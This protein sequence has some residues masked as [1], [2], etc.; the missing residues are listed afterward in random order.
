MK[1]YLIGAGPGDPELITL[2]AKKVIEKSDVIIYAGSLI[3]EE[4]LEFNNGAVKHNSADMNLDEITFIYK[5]AK[6]EEKNVAR[7][8]CGD[9][10]F[11]SAINEQIKI[12][13]KEGIDFEIIPGVGSM[14]AASAALGTQFTLPDVS[15]SIMI[16]RMG[17]KTAVPEM[18]RLSL[19]ARH[20]MTLCLYLSVHLIEEVVDSIMPA[21]G[22]ETPAAVVER[23]SWPDER[24]LIGKLSDL[25]KLVKIAGIK[26]TAL[27][28]VGDVLADQ[29]GNSKLYDKEFAH[30]FREKT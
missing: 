10:S 26:R 8:Q 29:G 21:Y 17:G 19:L 18:E 7:L 11:Y 14:A 6:S 3:N 5:Q 22:A 30:G 28:V 27:I 20:R 1:V 15:Q 13:K 4:I 25:P 23:A 2:K 16:T 9:L 24:V 12:L